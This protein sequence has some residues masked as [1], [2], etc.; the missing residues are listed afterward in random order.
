[1]GFLNLT[2]YKHLS[3]MAF[4][5]DKVI[6]RVKAAFPAVTV[7]PG[8]QLAE[9]VKRAEAFLA[10]ELKQNPTGPARRVIESLR[11]KAQTYGPA[12]AFH[13]PAPGG[14]Q[15]KG[16]ARSVGVEFHFDDSLPQ[17]TRQRLIEF[18]KSLGVGKLE[19]ST[20]DRQSEV[21]CDLPG[22]SECAHRT[23]SMAG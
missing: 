8:D 22:P 23:Q 14:G 3:R 10:E 16:L 12:Y 7:L 1:M 5:P 17:E 13:L 21:L 2:L 4:E 20:P 11:R 18:L 6:E 15:I 9:E 19:C